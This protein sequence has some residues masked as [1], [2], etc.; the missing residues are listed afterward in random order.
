MENG[1]TEHNILKFELAGD[2]G[3]LIKCLFIVRA[4][5]QACLALSSTSLNELRQHLTNS[6]ECTVQSVPT[7]TDPNADVREAGMSHKEKH[8]LLARTCHLRFDVLIFRVLE[9]DCVFNV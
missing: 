8:Y 9:C 1:A 2:E 7:P 3:G 6:C 4:R 5:W